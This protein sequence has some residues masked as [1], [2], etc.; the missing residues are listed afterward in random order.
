MEVLEIF[1]AAAGIVIIIV[2]FLIGE[3]SSES[4]GDTLNLDMDTWNLIMESCRKKLEK[5][6]EEFFQ[7][8]SVNAAE[9]TEDRLSELSN[10]KI[11]ELDEFS[12]QVLEK[13]E[14]NHSEVIFLY[15]TLSEKEKEM[16]DLVQQIDQSKLVLEEMLQ[17][18]KEYQ[19]LVKQRNEERSQ[20]ELKLA[21]EKKAKLAGKQAE[22]NRMVK[23]KPIQASQE[24]LQVNPAESRGKS[25]APNA[26]AAGGTSEKQSAVRRK[27]E[28]QAALMSGNSQP[29]GKM[30]E[31]IGQN[32]NEKIMALY[33]EGKSILEISKLLGQGQGEVKLV[34]DLFRGKA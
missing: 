9:A 23:K 2:S 11:M 22:A 18:Q 19:R 27:V 15:N 26:S 17:I 24:S 8:Y 4:D 33:K 28:T 25:E 30:A 32:S 29:V 21:A 3:K 14:R 7:T 10:K 12:Q 5:Q 1:L 13:I 16:K 31:G 34:V 6:T 20:T